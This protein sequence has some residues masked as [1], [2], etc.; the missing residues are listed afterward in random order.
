MQKKH[1]EEMRIRDKKEIAT[2]LVVAGCVLMY[3]CV[4]LLTRGFV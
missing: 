4:A 3:A 2:M 1:R